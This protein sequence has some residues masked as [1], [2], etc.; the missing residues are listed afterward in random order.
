MH[1]AN[2]GRS[3][4][5]GFPDQRHH[6]RLKVWTERRRRFIQKEKPWGNRQG[7]HQ[8]NALL[9]ATTEQNRQP[10]PKVPRKADTR[11]QIGDAFACLCTLHPSL[12]KRA[13]GEI[14]RSY[15]RHRPQEL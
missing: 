13:R 1:H 3:A 8:I 6:F 12:H 7:A 10:I 5:A 15:P 9:F 4:I 2:Q 11:E 14:N